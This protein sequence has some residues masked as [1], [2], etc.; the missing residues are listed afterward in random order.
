MS[1]SSKAL[2]SGIK[3]IKEMPS[4]GRGKQDPEACFSGTRDW[5][6]YLPNPQP[7]SQEE[8]LHFKNEE[9]ETGESWCSLFSMREKTSS[10]V[11]KSTRSA[12]FKASM[13]CS[14]PI[15][16]TVAPETCWTDQ[17]IGLARASTVALPLPDGNNLGILSEGKKLKLSKYLLL[18]VKKLKIKIC[19][20][21]ET[22]NFN[23]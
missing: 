14:K 6:T 7:S 9:M 2:E 18:I 3:L 21:K 12:N 20:S 8:S 10:N 4:Q 23:T 16:T 11:R 19:F 17:A 22:L 13:A 5:C 1:Q 15:V